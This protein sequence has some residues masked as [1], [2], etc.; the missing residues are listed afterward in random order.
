VSKVP[1]GAV[2]WLLSTHE[3]IPGAPAA[4]EHE[5]LVASGWPRVYVPPDAGELID[6]IGGPT[7]V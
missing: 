1:L 4:S 7:T 5:K 3:V 6:A 2:T